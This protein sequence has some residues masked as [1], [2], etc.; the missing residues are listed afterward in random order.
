MA[1]LDERSRWPKNIVSKPHVFTTALIKSKYMSAF[2]LE[3]FSRHRSSLPFYRIF[4][5]FSRK[6]ENSLFVSVYGQQHRSP[7][8]LGQAAF[9]RLLDVVSSISSWLRIVLVFFAA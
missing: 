6:N 8:V 4:H 7:V 3:R 2:P 5:P 1:L 9:L